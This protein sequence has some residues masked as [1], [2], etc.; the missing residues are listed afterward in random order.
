[1]FLDQ[2]RNV[3]PQVFNKLEIGHEHLVYFSEEFARHHLW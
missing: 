3:S 2:P 1:M